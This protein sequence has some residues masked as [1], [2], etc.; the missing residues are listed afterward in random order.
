MLWNLPEFISYTHW[1]VSRLPPKSGRAA[2]YSCAEY[3][4][5]HTFS[6]KHKLATDEPT[7]QPSDCKKSASSRV[8]TSANTCNLQIGIGTYR[9]L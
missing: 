6:N 8:L 4:Q 5:N 2:Y 7:R 1:L 3:Q 9:Y